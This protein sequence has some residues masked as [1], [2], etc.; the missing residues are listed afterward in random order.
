MRYRPMRFRPNGPAV[1]IARASG[2]GKRPPDDHSGPTGRPFWE[3]QKR[4]K[5]PARWAF[6]NSVVS[7]SWSDGP[8]YGN[9]WPVGPKT[10]LLL[11]TLFMNISKG[12][13]F[14]GHKDVWYDEPCSDHLRLSRSF[15]LPCSNHHRL[16][17]S[18]ALPSAAVIDM[19][20]TAA[21]LRGSKTKR[22]P[23]SQIGCHES[24]QRFVWSA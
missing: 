21:R 20:S 19:F 7:R 6:G 8:G 4:I 10:Q 5:R 22:Q 24:I 12:R 11:L 18:F 1:F 3:R 16:S 2:P 9:G 15:A 14:S 23:T 17:R 13:T